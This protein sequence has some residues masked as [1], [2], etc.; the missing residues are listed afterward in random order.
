[1]KIYKEALTDK[2]ED[3]RWKIEHAQVL[4]EQDFEYF[5]G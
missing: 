5:K 3:R 1:L 2:K 4:R